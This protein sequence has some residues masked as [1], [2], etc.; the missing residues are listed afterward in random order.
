V[1]IFT[2]AVVV[3]VS[4]K[5]EVKQTPQSDEKIN[6]YLKS[7]TVMTAEDSLFFTKINTFDSTM[8]NYAADPNYT[9]NKQYSADSAVWY[10]EALFNAKYAFTDERYIKTE[11]RT[12]TL[13]ISFNTDNLVEMD[14]I[15]VANNELFNKVKSMYDQ[16]TLNNKELIILDLE[17]IQID[18]YDVAIRI[19]PVFGEK[20]VWII[21]G[22]PFG[23]DDEWYYG[24]LLGD[25]DNN[26]IGTDAA[27]KI[28][29]AVMANRKVPAVI[30]YYSDIESVTREGYEYQDENGDYL[31][32]YILN[33]NGN[34]TVDDKCLIPDEMNFHFYGEETVIYD[35]VAV[36]LNKTFLTITMKGL[37][38]GDANNTPRIR[39]NNDL[40]YG[41]MRYGNPPDI[42]VEKEHL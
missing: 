40:E 15:A 32:F 29:G 3:V 25:C 33:A 5:K 20:G 9:Q 31:I 27:Q 12:D 42:G 23:D 6:G 16:S 18:N 8:Q 1:I 14:D 19:K 10:L 36:E 35:K 37:P 34:F 39:H 13:T 30:H 28:A 2:L 7:D 17:I 24:M 11:S 22:D 38:D 26:Y 21:T 4:C 41:I